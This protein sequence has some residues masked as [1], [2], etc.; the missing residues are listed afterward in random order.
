[1]TLARPSPIEARTASVPAAAI[2]SN[3]DMNPAAVR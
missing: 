1:M 3:A 2:P